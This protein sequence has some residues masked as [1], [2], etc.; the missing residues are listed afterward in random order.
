M[1]LCLVK[2]SQ[3]I[4]A[5]CSPQCLLPAWF[6][7]EL[8]NKNCFPPCVYFCFN[9]EPAR[10]WR[11]DLGPDTQSLINNKP[12]HRSTY[13]LVNFTETTFPY[14]QRPHALVVT[15]LS[16]LAQYPLTPSRPR[17]TGHIFVVTVLYRLSL[18]T[19]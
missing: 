13:L 9:L 5:T 12:V 1:A 15:V 6:S 14:S 18:C 8:T 16:W 17:H 10:G 2:N 19:V 4:N 11:E 7:D 3:I